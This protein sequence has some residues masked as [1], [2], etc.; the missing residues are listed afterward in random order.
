M[1]NGWM[2]EWTVKCVIQP[3]SCSTLI[4]INS[5]YHL[6][7]QWGWN[8][9]YNAYKNNCLAVIVQWWYWWLNDIV[10]AF[11]MIN[12][13]KIY[14]LCDTQDINTHGLLIWTF[15]LGKLDK[16]QARW[17]MKMT[18]TSPP[19]LP[20]PYSSIPSFIPPSCLSLCWCI[21]CVQVLPVHGS[22]L[23]PEMIPLWRREARKSWE[24]KKIS[25]KMG[26]SA[27]NY[28]SVPSRAWCGENTNDPAL[29]QLYSKR[30]DYYV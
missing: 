1:N 19:F 3:R 25:L 8:I 5:E 18:I 14:C 4:Q 21:I 7:N 30:C 26:S 20:L 16:R 29:C 24:E 28:R 15:T 9:L 11:F 23:L 6:D 22:W 2:D 10:H 13:R 12:A 27:V 17:C